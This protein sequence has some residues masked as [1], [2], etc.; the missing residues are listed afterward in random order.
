MYFLVQL[1]RLVDFKHGW[2]QALKQL[3]LLEH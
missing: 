3:S 1:K 2:I